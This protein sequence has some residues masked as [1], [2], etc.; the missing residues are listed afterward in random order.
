MIYYTYLKHFRGFIMSKYIL[1]VLLMLGNSIFACEIAS[2]QRMSQCFQ[3][4]TSDAYKK[5]QQAQQA[6]RIKLQNITNKVNST[7]KNTPAQ[8]PRPQS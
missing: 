3:K 7:L 8:Y 6:L 5:A 2:G 4:A 1:I